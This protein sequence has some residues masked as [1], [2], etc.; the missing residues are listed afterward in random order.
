MIGVGIP[1]IAGAATGNAASGILASLGALYAGFNSFRGSYVARLRSMAA[2]SLLMALA[3]LL[4]SLSSGSTL[5]SSIVVAV[6]AFGL[7]LFSSLSLTATL[8]SIQGTALLVV[9]AGLPSTSAHPFGNA[10]LVLGGGALQIVIMTLIWP[11]DPRYPERKAVERVYLA[12]AQHVRD[13]R[14]GNA[15]LIPDSEFLTE[16][17]TMVSAIHPQPLEVLHPLR[18]GETI[19][20]CLVGLAREDARLREMDTQSVARADE[21]LREL[22]KALVRVARDI[23]QGRAPRFDLE[24][25]E[26]GRGE[27]SEHDRWSHL[28]F[29]ALKRL[30]TPP[31]EIPMI[32]TEA[33]SFRLR[34]LFSTAI[35]RT[36][37]IQHAIR[38]GLGIAAANAIGHVWVTPHAYWLPLSACI[39]LRSDY[40]TTINRG[41]ARLIGTVVGVVVAGAIANLAPHAI[42]LSAMVLVTAWLACSVYLSNYALFTALITCFAVFSVAATAE[43]QRV[44]SGERLLATLAGAA[45]AI[46]AN[47]LWP[48]W[49]SRKVAEVLGS[50]VDCQIEYGEKVFALSAGGAITAAD[51]ARH[52]A[53]TVRL[54]AEKIVEAALHEPWW[55][56]RWLPEYYQ[57]AL[58][59]I[60]ENAAVLLSAH[61]EAIHARVQGR[62]ARVPPEAERALADSRGLRESLAVG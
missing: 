24:F 17:R 53:R 27:W 10:G 42:G 40:A 12:L 61:A 16:A 35:F 48:I 57:S 37:S 45:I 44:A 38:Y 50:A 5:G 4:G 62:S 49:Q 56:R 47:L 34:T 30:Q 18:V 59:R 14:V 25:S 46:L 26:P 19:R 6:W 1:L 9:C 36:L 58:D 54:E 32:L 22:E 41:V 8:L 21:V 28:I 20:A 3:T 11:F 29:E 33:V 13:I 51:L 55:S 7:A 52:R 23:R 31:E 39:L 2:T 60:D 43:A 15:D